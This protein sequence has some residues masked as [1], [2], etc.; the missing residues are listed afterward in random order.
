METD[1][2]LL[3]A[4]AHNLTQMIAQGPLA[5]DANAQAFVA[6]LLRAARSMNRRITALEDEIERLRG[7]LRWHE[8]NGRHA[9]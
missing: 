6:E 5:Y 3:M 2:S 8:K 7:D 1:T 9:K 4:G